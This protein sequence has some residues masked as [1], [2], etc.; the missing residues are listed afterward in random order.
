MVLLSQITWQTETSQGRNSYVMYALAWSYDIN[1]QESFWVSDSDPPAENLS[2][3]NYA[4]F[5]V[6]SKLSHA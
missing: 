3:T 6:I 1:P 5:P 2:L 4:P